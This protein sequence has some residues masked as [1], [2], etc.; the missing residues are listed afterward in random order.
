MTRADAAALAALAALALGLLTA[1]AAVISDVPFDL[2]IPL[3]AGWRAA[4]GQWPH[5]DYH[6]PVGALYHALYGLCVLALGRTERVLLVAPVLGAV[7][8]VAAALWVSVGRLE[9]LHRALFVV[10]AGCCAMSPRLLDG[11]D[12]AFLASYNRIGWALVAVGLVQLAVP[13]P[14][15]RSEAVEGAVLT[16]ILL[17]LALLKI[18]YFVALGLG[19]GLAL[20][21]VPTNRRL[22]VG[23]GAASWGVLAA[24]ALVSELPWAYLDD[25]GRA[26]ASYLATSERTGADKLA[27]DLVANAPTLGLA[28]AM[29]A[30]AWRF[31]D[32]RRAAAAV[33][34]VLALGLLTAQQSHDHHVPALLVAVVLAAEAL[35]RAL[36]D[37]PLIAAAGLG[38]AALLPVSQDAVAIGRNA[39]LSRSDATVAAWPGAA[40]RFPG[41][42][43]DRTLDPVAEGQLSAA[44]WASANAQLTGADLALL[45]T[46]GRELVLARVTPTDHVLTIASSPAFSWISGTVPPRGPDAWYDHGRTFGPNRP[47]DVAA[48]LAEVTLVMEPLPLRTDTI[49]RVAQALEPAL[50]ADFE[51]HETPL[52]RLWVRR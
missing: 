9:P 33:G 10:W 51:P 18:T 28:A 35:R 27:A 17:A 29:A 50:E 16:A 8:V 46:D 31:G 49:D 48:T 20:A 32:E 4:N 38:L 52:W 25:L 6:T 43:A 37:Q 19:C 12:L 11:P 36:P 26:A 21:L 7:P 1:P 23:A 13:R 39:A 3:D 41:S 14:A 22:A 30:G 42:A 34:A 47:I 2:F 44:A 40:V 24:F 5:L 15:D 45:L